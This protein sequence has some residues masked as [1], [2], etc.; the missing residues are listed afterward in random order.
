MDTATCV[1]CGRDLP[2]AVRSGDYDNHVRLVADPYRAE[3]AGVD[4]ANWWCGSC[5]ADRAADI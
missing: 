1:G 3:I 2:I 4:E 5:F